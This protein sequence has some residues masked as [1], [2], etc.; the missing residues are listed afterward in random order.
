[1]GRKRKGGGGRVL[2]AL[3]CPCCGLVTP[4][5]WNAWRA[6]REPQILVRYIGGNKGIRVLRGYSYDDEEVLPFK[7]REAWIAL[8]EAT[9]ERLRGYRR[10]VAPDRVSIP[11]AVERWERSPIPEPRTSAT[12]RVVL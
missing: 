6:R 10:L 1:M 4:Y 8:L 12:R 2:L 9:L 11:R 5:R 3:R 7:F